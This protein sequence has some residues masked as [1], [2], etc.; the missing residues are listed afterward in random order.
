MGS[1]SLARY[2]FALHMRSVLSVLNHK[3][4]TS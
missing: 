1:V 3:Q 4:E 2:A